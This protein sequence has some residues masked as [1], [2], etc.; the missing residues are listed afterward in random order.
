MVISKQITI[1]HFFRE[2]KSHSILKNHYISVLV[3]EFASDD[4]ENFDFFFFFLRNSFLISSNDDFDLLFS[5]EQYIPTMQ[6]TFI[7]SLFI[8]MINEYL[9]L[10]RHF[11][12]RYRNKYLISPP[13]HPLLPPPLAQGANC[14]K[15]TNKNQ[16]QLTTACKTVSRRHP[17]H[18]VPERWKV[19]C[20]VRE[21]LRGGNT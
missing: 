5:T 2:Y 3:T 12:E 1:V 16:E 8:I 9:L 7:P 14:L 10:I 6:P 20:E 17:Y 4:S 18:T 13:P 19:G 11:T 15:S 21:G